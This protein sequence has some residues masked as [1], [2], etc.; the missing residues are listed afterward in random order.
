MGS[1][2]LCCHPLEP[3][4]DIF[5]P[6]MGV[7][8]EAWSTSSCGRSSEWGSVPTGRVGQS[9]CLA[10]VTAA[11]VSVPQSRCAWVCSL[12]TSRR[13]S[14]QEGLCRGLGSPGYG[15][16]CWGDRGAVLVLG[17]C[18]KACVLSPVTSC[19]HQLRGR[20]L[21]CL[22]AFCE[23]VEG[24]TLSVAACVTVSAS[25]DVCATLP[26]AEPA[27]GKEAATSLGQSIDMSSPGTRTESCAGDVGGD[28]CSQHPLRKFFC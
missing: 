7:G 4:S 2:G 24:S 6:P 9:L 8:K 25:L 5:V 12:Q 22:S 18:T 10:L 11:V 23:E 14:P 3:V 17:G 28:S 26:V 20:A 19:L 15:Q 21:G 1:P 27:A 13:T 16:G